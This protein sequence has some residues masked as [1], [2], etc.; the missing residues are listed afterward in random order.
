LI[1]AA[2]DGITDF[3][4]KRALIVMVFVGGVA[5]AGPPK[6]WVAFGTPT[7]TGKLDAKAV[8]AKVTPA[9]PKLVDCY[10]KATAKTPAIVTASVS[11]T[12][13]IEASGKVTNVALTASALPKD[14]EPCII[15]TIASIK[16]TA[17]K[18]GEPI[19]VTYPLTFDPGLTPPGTITGT[20]GDV[21]DGNADDVATIGH[22]SGWGGSM[23]SGGTRGTARVTMLVLGQP[24]VQGDL[25]KA[26]IRRYIKRNFQRLQ[27]CYEKE[28]QTNATLGGTVTAKFTIGVDGKVSASTATGLKEVESC[29][30][31]ALQSIEFPKPKSGKAV[32]VTYPLT[33]RA[34]PK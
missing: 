7:I 14:A 19:Q 5:S 11:A 29:V 13:T 17:R 6:P 28:L 27:Y 30:T 1:A 31:S 9:A 32:S 25:D 12:F 10:K 2:R 21:A 16:F 3:M 8:S 34:P 4:H 20:S 33:Y 15:A 24:T 22:G 18:G 23:S 26:I